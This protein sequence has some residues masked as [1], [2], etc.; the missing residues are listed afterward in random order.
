MLSR[1]LLG[2]NNGGFC[3][4]HLSDVTYQFFCVRS[5]PSNFFPRQR[6]TELKNEAFIIHDVSSV[7]YHLRCYNL[8]QCQ[9]NSTLEHPTKHGGVFPKFFPSFSERTLV[10]GRVSLEITSQIE[11]LFIKHL[12]EFDA[13]RSPR[14]ATGGILRDEL[15]SFTPL[16]VTGALL[17]ERK[18]LKDRWSQVTRM[19]VLVIGSNKNL[20][21]IQ[22]LFYILIKLVVPEMELE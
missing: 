13:D 15:R 2:Y 5:L 4:Q 1:P 10:L 11:K 17:L 14:V 6:K 21:K 18:M 9:H 19:G 16:E 3:R 22:F 7:D 12:R 20:S 8:V